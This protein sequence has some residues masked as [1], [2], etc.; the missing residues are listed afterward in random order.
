MKTQKSKYFKNSKITIFDN[1]N[2][3]V[4]D[5]NVSNEVSIYNKYG[6]E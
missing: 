5:D 6:N 2:I 3:I 4:H 1:Y